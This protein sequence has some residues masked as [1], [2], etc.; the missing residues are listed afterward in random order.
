M[1]TCVFMPHNRDQVIRYRHV[2]LDQVL[3][4][5]YVIDMVLNVLF[6]WSSLSRI[7]VIVTN[8]FFFE[9]TAHLT[10]AFVHVMIQI[11]DLIN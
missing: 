9:V 2:T 8:M 6:F 5:D 3:P 11:W 1:C 4:L 7:H 10:F